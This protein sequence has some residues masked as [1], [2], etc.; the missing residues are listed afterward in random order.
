MISV[1]SVY[2][3]RCGLDD[4]IKD[5]FCDELLDVVSKLGEKV[6]ANGSWRRE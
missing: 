4:C 1:V 2:A 5:K 3:P 6:I